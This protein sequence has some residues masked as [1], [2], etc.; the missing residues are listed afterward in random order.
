MFNIGV[1]GQYLVAMGTASIA[2]LHFGL[3]GRSSSRVVLIFAMLGGMAWAAVPAVLKVKTGAHEVV[4][5]IMMNGIAVFLVAWAL[6]GSLKYTTPNGEFKVDLRT[7]YFPN[8]ALVP[9]LGHY[10]RRRN[11]DTPL[12]WLLPIGIVVRGAGLV[13]AEAHPAGVRG[14]RGGLVAG[15]GRAP[16]GSASGACR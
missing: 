4:T 6:N 7:D 5:T 2:A 8:S 10:P 3:L 1:E 15:L 9:N 12:S 14:A 16:A 11:P 13:P